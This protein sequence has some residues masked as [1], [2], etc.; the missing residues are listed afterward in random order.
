[1]NI[2]VHIKLH[3]KLPSR[4]GL[5]SSSFLISQCDP[6]LNKL[7]VVDILGDPLI[8]R[9][10]LELSVNPTF[11]FIENTRKFGVLKNKIEL[12][13]QMKKYTYEWYKVKLI[14]FDQ[15]R[16]NGKFLNEVVLPY[17]FDLGSFLFLFL[18]FVFLFFRIWIWKLT[19]D[20]GWSA[21]LFVHIWCL[22]ILSL[23]SPALR[24]QF[25]LIILRSSTQIPL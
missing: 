21:G 12:D 20:F 22:V 18:H 19:F 11:T 10:I 14:G 16:D 1:M 5:R 3:I 6:N 13:E 17:V 8:M 9:L 23:K 25:W 7:Q 24:T 15:R 2:F 4:Y